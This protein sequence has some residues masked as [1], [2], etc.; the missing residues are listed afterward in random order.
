MSR[1]STLR[2]IG[3]A[4]AFA[5]TVFATAASANGLFPFIQP[6]AVPQAAQAPRDADDG[7]QQIE[8]LRRQVVDYPSREAAGTVIVDTPHTYL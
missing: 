2:C 1:L 8:R 6:F 4:S 3:L 5:V 7:I